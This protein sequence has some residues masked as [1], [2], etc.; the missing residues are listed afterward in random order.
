MRSSRTKATFRVCRRYVLSSDFSG[1]TLA[2]RGAEEGQGSAKTLAISS[3]VL[4][5]VVPTWLI[6]MH[7]NFTSP[8]WLCSAC[9]RGMCFSVFS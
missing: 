7:M 2:R 9:K 3:C 8:Q 5:M 6:G 4:D 1:V